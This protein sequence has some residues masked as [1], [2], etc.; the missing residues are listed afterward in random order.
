VIKSLEPLIGFLGS[1]EP[2]LWMKNWIG[3]KLYSYKHCPWVYFTAIIFGCNSPT[4]FKVVSCPNPLQM[5]K[6]C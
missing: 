4:D 1:M 2:K 3:K 6:T 5:G